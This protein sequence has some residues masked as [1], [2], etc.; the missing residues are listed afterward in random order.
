MYPMNEILQFF[1]YI[2]ISAVSGAVGGLIGAWL[3]LWK[4]N[5]LDDED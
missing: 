4:F 3:V 1:G 5:L 2:F